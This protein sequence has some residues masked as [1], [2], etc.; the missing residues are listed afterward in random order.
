MLILL[1]IARSS[2]IWVKAMF[3][4]AILGKGEHRTQTLCT[5]D[6]TRYIPSIKSNACYDGRSSRETNWPTPRSRIQLLQ[7]MHSSTACPP[8]LSYALHTV[9]ALRS[10]PVSN[11]SHR[12]RTMPRRFTTSDNSALDLLVVL[13]LVIAPRKHTRNH[14]RQTHNC[15]H[16]LP[17]Q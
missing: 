9:S 1:T 6:A 14:Q 3:M 15:G 8:S 10:C 12:V 4:P 16:T 13:E 11:N 7:T 5:N 2:R 17:L